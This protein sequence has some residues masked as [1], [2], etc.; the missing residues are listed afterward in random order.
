MRIPANAI[1]QA[2]EM[3]APVVTARPSQ[4][5][6]A[7]MANPL[8][9]LPLLA[10]LSA[11][12]NVSS[13][14]AL[15]GMATQRSRDA[16]NL[17][18]NELQRTRE[19]IINQGTGNTILGAALLASLLGASPEAIT[20]G[21]QNFAQGTMQRRQEEEARRMALAQLQARQMQEQGEL[22][23]RT[24][25]AVQ[26]AGQ[27]FR[28][29]QDDARATISEG[30]MRLAQS[31]DPVMVQQG[32]EALNQVAQ[33]AGIAGPTAGAQVRTRLSAEE[34]QR[35]ATAVR[36]F[37]R[38]VRESTIANQQRDDIARGINST[39]QLIGR[40]G[41]APA[42]GSALDQSIRNW[43]AQTSQRAEQ[44]GEVM[45]PLEAILSGTLGQ[46]R[47]AFQERQL[48]ARER[49]HQERLASTADQKERDRLNRIEV[50]RI[51]ADATLE[52]ARM[53]VQGG[54]TLEQTERQQVVD[55]GVKRIEQNFK[56]AE[57]QTRRAMN[58]Q[59]T[60]P[61]SAQLRL[62]TAEELRQ[63]ALNTLWKMA[64]TLGDDHPRVKALARQYGLPLPNRQARDLARGILNS[65]SGGSQPNA[66]AG[67]SNP[68]N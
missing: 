15:L 46:E 25:D 64:D 42:P 10:G 65:W 18:A 22:A 37:N 38:M 67:G 44:I 9:V 32:I 27:R 51:R 61:E 58:T 48:T 12:S 33:R 14:N 49:M 57:D 66:P 2:M 19:P 50:A 43:Y 30:M 41:R 26:Q 1:R 13:P 8:A 11:G 35:E 3:Q 39:V 34:R 29:M 28:K 7:G 59:N 20:G 68:G 16:N 21:F 62:Q 52:S 17:L 63:D 36:E 56:D 5:S 23:G 40:L 54:G 4:V 24:A 47:Q 60:D 53:R 6:Q 45:P 31:E 55:A